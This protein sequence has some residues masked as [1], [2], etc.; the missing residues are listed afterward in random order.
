[1]FPVEIDRIT[2]LLDKIELSKY[3]STRNYKNGAVS[4]LSPYMFLEEF[5][6]LK[7]FI[8]TLD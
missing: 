6:Q 5:S 1:M 8:T 3:E 4:R 2:P 7:Q